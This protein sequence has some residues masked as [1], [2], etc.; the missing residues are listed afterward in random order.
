[1]PKRL[2]V[3][4]DG[5]WNAFGQKNSTNVV[6]VFKAVAPTDGKG[7]QQ[8]PLYVAGVGTK[9]HEKV[10]GGALGFGLSKNVVE[11]YTKIVERFEPG[12][13]I[14]LFGFSR[15]AYT[16]RSLAGFIRN[17]GILKPENQDRIDEAF[18]LYRD[19]TE[20]TAPS[21]QRARD[22]RDRYSHETDIEFV[23]VWDTVGSLG[24]PID[25]WKFAEKINQRWAF[26]DT[27]LSNSVKAAYHAL[28]IDEKRE[29]FKPTLWKPRPDRGET[30]PLEQVWFSGVH[31]NVGGGYASIELSNIPLV[32]MMRNAHNHGLRFHNGDRSAVA[33]PV[34]DAPIAAASATVPPAIRPLLGL[35]NALARLDESRKGMY[36]VF[37]PF[38]RPI[39]TGHQ[40]SEFAA[41]SAEW[42]KSV[43]NNYR[44]PKLVEYLNSNGPCKAVDYL[45]SKG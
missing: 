36:L 28:A 5:T 14:F 4:C 9:W 31:C 42:R 6:K 38:A 1:M 7:V 10:R 32:W 39:G 12:D 17:C 34:A 43:D 2:V 21:A 40:A 41:S 35:T 3:C 44:P 33:A 26:H 25:G 20:E 29:P 11:G 15:G 45:P 30:Q 19:R 18:V 13:E 23:G 37:K 24:I 16:A 22:F 27:S 8:V